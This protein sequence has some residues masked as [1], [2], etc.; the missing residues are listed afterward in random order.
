MTVYSGSLTLA[1]LEIDA[2]LAVSSIGLKQLCLRSTRMSAAEDY[3]D[4]AKVQRIP[5]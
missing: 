4:I 1:G 5:D 2:N 3:A